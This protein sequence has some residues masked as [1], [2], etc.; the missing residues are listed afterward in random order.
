MILTISDSHKNGKGIP[1]LISFD[2]TILIHELEIDNGKLLHNLKEFDIKQFNTIIF[3][4]NEDLFPYTLKWNKQLSNKFSSSN[5]LIEHF[6]SISQFIQDISPQ[7]IIYQK[8]ENVFELCDKVKTYEKL[9]KINLEIFKIPK[10]K[11]INS[12][13]DLTTVDFFPLILK[14]TVGSHTKNDFLCKNHKELLSYYNEFKNKSNIFCVEYIDSFIKEIDTKHSMR[15]MITNDQIL[16]F[17]LRPSKMW[18]IHTNDQDT[19]KVLE[20]DEYAKNFFKRNNDFIKKDIQNIYQIYGNGFF[21]YDVI[22]K[23]HKLY[24]C[25]IGLKYFDYTQESLI[26]KTRLKN[27]KNSLSSKYMKNYYREIIFHT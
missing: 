8:P 19:E 5:E 9:S 4:I 12:F 24:F 27:F 23:D 10:F 6:C 11:A 14:K 20:A 13:E 26:R 15:I 3:N 1:N 18:N 17:Y 22:L 7:T 25:E 16:D 2:K 21:S